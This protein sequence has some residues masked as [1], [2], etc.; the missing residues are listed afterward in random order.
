MHNNKVI[1]YI[2]DGWGIGEKINNNAIY[3]AKTPFYDYLYKNYP[4]STLKTH[5]QHVGLPNDQ[6]GNSEVG[7]MNIG[8]GRVIDQDL[9]RINNSI[10]YN[11]LIYNESLINIISLIKNHNKKLHIL[12]LVSDGGVHS[13][14]NHLIAILKILKKNDISDHVYIHAI[15]DGRDNN[16]YSSLKHIQRI[17]YICKNTVGKL[18]TVMGRYYAMDRDKKWE[19]TKIAYD[20]LVYGKGHL[21][22]NFIESIKNSHSN[23]KTDEFI[24]PLIKN[25]EGYPLSTL[26]NNDI[27]LSFNYRT[28]RTRQITEVLTQIPVNKMLPLKL[29]YYTMTCYNDTYKNI[30]I[31][32]PKK[33]VPMTLGEVLS[34]NNMTQLRIAES[35]KFPHVTYFFSGGIH[36]AFIKEDRV[37]ISSPAVKSYDLIPQMSI[38]NLEKK[39]SY[40][41]NSNKYN[42]ICVNIANP[43]MVGHTGN[44]HSTVKAIEHVDSFLEKSIKNAIKCLYTILII[45]DHGNAEYMFDLNS[46]MS[47]TT[48]T[49]NLTPLI[50]LHNDAKHIESGRLCDIAPTILKIMNLNIPFEMKGNILI[51]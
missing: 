34:Q 15:T 46:K 49:C 17:Q 40:S 39:L 14:I 31:I 38:S 30:N 32:F 50:L 42:F 21:T 4:N 2:L 18:S 3:M 26:N 29:N 48:H 8:S 47:N 6:F 9:V 12:G 19:R 36:N 33:N 27:V 28:D 22:N 35:E 25:N 24:L 13:H 16:Q 37:S 45:S 11:E 23:G 7:H 43:D 20:A 44:F 10:K 5:G 51:K 1:L 41:I